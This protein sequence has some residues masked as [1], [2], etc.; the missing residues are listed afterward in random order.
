MRYEGLNAGKCGT[1]LWMT[2]AI[3]F[4]ALKNLDTVLEQGKSRIHKVRT[5]FS[6]LIYR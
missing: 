1:S 4:G 5:H 3:V 6:I 2:V